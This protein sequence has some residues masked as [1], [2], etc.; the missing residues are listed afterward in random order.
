[1]TTP[2]QIDWLADAQFQRTATRP[3]R[4]RRADPQTSHEAAK[5]AAEFASN[6]EARIFEAIKASAARGATAKEI[7][8]VADLTD[9]QVSRRLKAMSETERIERR[10]LTDCSGF[11]SRN[12]CAIW[13]ARA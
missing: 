10:A 9:V 2:H 4:A 8:A 3:P 5:R 12:G 1:M 7:A 6:H 13:W 11:E